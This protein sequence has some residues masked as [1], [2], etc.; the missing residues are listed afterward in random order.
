MDIEAGELSH[1]EF[2]DGCWLIPI[3][4]K[5]NLGTIKPSPFDNTEWTL[6]SQLWKKFAINF[7]DEG[8]S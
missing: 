5:R 4:R 1:W 8:R 2:T 3:T 7:S 6:I